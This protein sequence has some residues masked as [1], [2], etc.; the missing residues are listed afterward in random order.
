MADHLTEEEQIEAI[1]GWWS[2][3]WISVVLP[4]VVLA[5]L[6][7]GWNYWG[8]YKRDR[9][10]LASD[11][12]EQLLELVETYES[13]PE[14][15]DTA[16]SNVLSVAQAIK[17]EALGSYSDLAAMLIARFAVN[18]EDFD[19]AAEALKDV[20]ANG[21]N[22]P[23]INIAR[24]RLARVYLAQEKFSEAIALVAPVESPSVKSLYSEV[25]GDI[26]VAQGELAAA[27]TAYQD[28]I[29][30]LSQAQ[31]N[32]RGILQFKLDGARTAAP[33]VATINEESVE[34]EAAQ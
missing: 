14:K 10:Q 17:D 28:A 13:S 31:G 7:T 24:A 25:R 5:L 8:D 23:T 29:A 2:E 26:Y 9:S 1:K 34:Q 18:D 15:S 32:H 27:H 16:K 21:A 6:Y 3:N 12:Y 4:I 22:E 33:E 30:S 11:K 19:T 20:V